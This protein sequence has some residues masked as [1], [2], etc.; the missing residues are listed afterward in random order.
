[1]RASSCAR[2]S[3]LHG[4]KSGSPG[5]HLNVG[6]S[7]GLLRTISARQKIDLHTMGYPTQSVVHF[8]IKMW[9]RQPCPSRLCLCYGFFVS[10]A[11][12]GRP[13][14]L[15]PQPSENSFL[16]WWDRDS[17]ATFELVRQ[18]VNSLIILGAWI[19]WNHRNCCVFYGLV[20]SVV[21]AL[22]LAGAECRLWISTGARG[23][24]LLYAPLPSD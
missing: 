14:G 18:G 16:D 22:I 3:L 11:K 7:C 1:M 15:Y 24:S 10:F 9:N 19:L 13:S 21:G 6:S 4:R 17:S 8:V 2:P 12:T 5:H 20:P 23:L